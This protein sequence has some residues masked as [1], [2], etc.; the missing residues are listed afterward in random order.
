MNVL[1]V[2]LLFYYNGCLNRRENNIIF[3]IKAF[4][5]TFQGEG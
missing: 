5:D 4:L 1:C 2:A 3:I